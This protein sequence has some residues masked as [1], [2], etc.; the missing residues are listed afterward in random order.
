[1]SHLDNVL[2]PCHLVH[3]FCHFLLKHG[4]VAENEEGNGFDEA[5]PMRIINVDKRISLDGKTEI[6]LNSS[7]TRAG[8]H[9]VML[10]YDPNL[11]VPR[12]QQSHCLHALASLGAVQPVSACHCTGNS[13]QA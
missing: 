1:M 3:G 6:S 10:N 2:K 5:M 11:P 13:Q 8:G 12:Q 9:M 7:K 4:F